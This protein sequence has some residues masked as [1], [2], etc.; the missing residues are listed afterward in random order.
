MRLGLDSPWAGTFERPIS[1]AV[2]ARAPCWTGVFFYL[3]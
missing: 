1:A 3:L 2:Q